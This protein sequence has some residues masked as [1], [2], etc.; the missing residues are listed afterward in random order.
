MEFTL[1][2]SGGPD[3]AH[4]SRLWR[5]LVAVSAADGRPLAAEGATLPRELRDGE[6]LLAEHGGNVVGYAHLDA[7]GDA[8]GHAVAELFVDP[9]SRDAGAGT[10]LAAEVAR[11]AGEAGL[12]FWSHGDDPAAARVAGR[13]GLQRVR[14]LVR[15]RCDLAGAGPAQVRLPDGVRIRG[16]VPGA[17]EAAVVRVN[18][19]AFAA[20]P[21]QGSMTEADVRSDEA[22]GWFDASG[23]LLAVDAEDRLLG[24]H[25]TK[26]H[27][28]VV[29][30][31]SG[32]PMGEMYVIAVDPGAHGR[33]L[34]TALLTAGLR[35]L[36]QAGLAE[37][38]LY[39]ESDNTAAIRM[40][41][42]AGFRRWDT[43]VQYARK[44]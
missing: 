23:F 4:D 7:G 9:E 34:G 39:V 1:T 22:E 29:A 28:A 32:Q 15:M 35:H 11:R 16:F 38:M 40:Y 24:F 44:R 43:D 10:A 8:F 14:A 37:A 17:D 19:R 25:W 2:W 41:E 36:R 21:E 26:V 31:P 6:Q 30:E 3:A 42:A 20:H 18:G 12:R 33:G 5:F 13:L 27:Q